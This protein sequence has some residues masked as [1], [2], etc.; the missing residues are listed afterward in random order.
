LAVHRA[1]EMPFINLARKSQAHG[2]R[3]HSPIT[4][5]PSNDRPLTAWRP[6]PP[7]TSQ[8][9]RAELIK[10]YYFYAAPPRFF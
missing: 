10:K 6:R 3:Q 2:G 5:D 4:R 9:G 8:K 7:K 1:F